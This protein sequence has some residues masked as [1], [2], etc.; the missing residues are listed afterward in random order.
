MAINFAGRIV[1]IASDQWVFFGL[2]T[3]DLSGHV[4]E[5]GHKE[6]EDGWFQRIGEY[7]VDGVNIHG[8]DGRNH[9]MPWSAAFISWV[10]DSGQAGDRFL[11][12]PQHS[13][14]IAQAIRDRLQGRSAAGYWGWRLNELKPSTGDL[15]CWSRQPGIDYDHQNSGDYA[16][17]CDIIVD[18]QPHEILV[19]GGNVGNSVT[20]RPLGLSD[21]GF[22]LPAV[23]SNEYIFAVMQNKIT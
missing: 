8:V 2:Q 14:Y 23:Q 1:G 22:V 13:V 18:V 5:L 9:E 11:Y 7:W 16:G 4:T 19:I 21:S 6:G 15:I 3:Y 12:S 20:K 17:H 10:M